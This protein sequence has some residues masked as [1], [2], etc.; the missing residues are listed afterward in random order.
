[1]KKFWIIITVILVGQFCYAQNQ[2]LA[3]SL[4]DVY[5]SGSYQMDELDLLAD[6]ASNET[7]PQTSL[8]YAE[9]IISKAIR[10]SLF[11]HLYSGYLQKGNA[12]QAAGKNVLALEA[13]FQCQKYAL[14]MGNEKYLGSSLISIA[15][16][17][18]N[19]DNFENAGHYYNES[20]DLLR[21]LKDS[22]GIASALTNLGDLYITQNKLDSALIYT[23]E[24]SAIFNSINHVT[25]K[26]YSVGNMGMIYAK[27][28][29][30][31][32]AE[33]NLRASIEILD[34]LGDFY[35]VCVYLTYMSDI[36]L[37]KNDWAQA[38]A[39]A[40]NS[41]DLAE[42]YNLKEQI[43]DAHLK[44]SEL[45]EHKEDYKRSNNH[46]KNYYSFRDSILNI[47]TVEKMADLRTD[48]E[49]AQKQIEVDLLNEKQVK[50]RITVT[51][52]IVALVLISLLALGLL[53]RNRFIEKTSHIIKGERDRSD[54]LLCNILPEKTAQ[55]LKEAGKVQAKHFE[56]VTVM[57]TD[58]KAFT[59]NSDQ[60]SPEELVESIDFYFSK[61][62]EIMEKYGLE[63]IKTI[64]D[65]YMCAG[66]L[67]NPTSDHAHKM[68]EA[69]IEIA[70]FV[71]ESKKE[72]PNNLTRFDIR[73]GINTG[74]VVAGVVGTK[75]FAYDI[76][77]DTV[78]IAS[79]MESNSEPGKI[80]ISENTYQ[81][82][83]DDFDCSY[84]GKIEAKHKG[85]LKM[86]F[87][88]AEKDQDEAEN[89]K[90][91]PMRAIRMDQY[92]M[93]S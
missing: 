65:A 29:N 44:L 76:W 36:Y 19:I 52:A 75:K 81:L 13:Y 70:A 68:I 62:D 6:I 54:S 55:E 59:A 85:Q 35:P 66:G 1:M 43:S 25:G 63:K 16:T 24:A 18:A 21:K 67:P 86:Y 22:I 88:H 5:N 4:I 12:L 57:F 82:I 14:R 11:N 17:Y 8:Q 50:Q 28:G 84:R 23:Q 38:V 83:K 73:I 93:N 46:L 71:D 79:R 47:K 48:F 92:S 32:I 87:V 61:F 80:N 31:D 89:S 30:D 39:Y 41:L 60:L 15:G 64:G 53:H 9:S 40:Q 2:K 27:Q 74:P 3:D 58:F 90:E 91:S 51:S 10:D 20:I 37:R 72:D 69:A 33:F 7:D 34:D 56:S 78:N 42:T 45:Y 49:L 77:G 26:A